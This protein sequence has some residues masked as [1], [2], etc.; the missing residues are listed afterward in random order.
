MPA[1]GAMNRRRSSAQGADRERL[2]QRVAQVVRATGR[3]SRRRRRRSVALLA[4]QDELDA[5]QREERVDLVDDRAV[6]GAIS[7]ARPPVA[8]TGACAP[9][10]A[11]M[12]SAMPST[13]PAKP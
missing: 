11:R 2:E 8:I 5:A 13:W 3:G 9:S 6:C 12:A 1:M 7:A 10:S 4:A